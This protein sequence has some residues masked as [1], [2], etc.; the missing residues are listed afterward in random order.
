MPARKLND[1]IAE[2]RERVAAD[3]GDPR[4]LYDD[5]RHVED[6]LKAGHHK[7][8]ADL[9]EADDALEAEILEEFYDNLP[10]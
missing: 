5:L 7:I 8:P 3:H 2:I 9:V 4:V 1:D 10:V 6:T